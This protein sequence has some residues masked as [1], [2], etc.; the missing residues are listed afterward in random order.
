MAGQAARYNGLA[1]GIRIGIF[2]RMKI[3]PVAIALVFTAFPA[4]AAAADAPKLAGNLMGLVWVLPFVAILLGIALGPL[5]AAHFWHAHYGK[6]AVACAV[7]FLAPCAAI[8]GADVALYEFLHTMLLEYIP[9]IVML[10]AL[11]VVACGVRLRGDLVGTPALNTGMLAFG[12]LIASVMG[13]TGACMLLIQPMLRA[14]A[15]RKKNVHVF[16]FFIFLVGNIGGSLTPLGDP[17]LFIG[18]LEGVDFFWTTQSML[19]PMLLVAVPLL[20]AF[21]ALDSYFHRSEGAPPKASGEAFA[22]EGKV[23]LLLLAGIIAAVLMS[24]VW[25][26]NL[27]LEIYYTPVALESIVRSVLLLALAWASLKLTDNES[28][29]ANGFSWEPIA[30]VAKLFVGIFVTIVPVLA[31]IRAGQEGALGGLIALLNSNG[32]P[33]NPMYFWITG[34]LSGFLDNAPTYLLFF[35]LAG[36]DPDTLMGPL[37][38]TLLAISCGSVFMGALTYIGNAPNFMVKA[39]AEKGGIKMPSFFGYMMWSCAFLL[40]LFALVTLVYFR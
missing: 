28:R 5:L 21:Y 12:T 11:Y 38:T 4:L 39:V 34:I 29:M 35:N 3:M 19:G 36:G 17:P 32:Q 22:V 16:V 23:N 26:P 2:A 14:N 31:I 20:I 10:F 8:F 15:W 18:F 25:R 30:E 27:P 6:F 33:D 1:F 24:G 9:F 40:P 7:A 37:A 13:T